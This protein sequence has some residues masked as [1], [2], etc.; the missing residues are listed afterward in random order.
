M[1][2][3]VQT[4][5]AL[6][7]EPTAPSHATNIKWVQEFFQ[8]LKKAPVRL[9]AVADQTGTFNVGDLEFTYT[10]QGPVDID[11]EEVDENDRILFTHQT[12]A[13]ENLLYVCTHKGVAGTDATVL[14]CADDFKSDI[15]PGMTVSVTEGDDHA[16]STWRLTTQG[17]ITAG[18]TALTWEPF[19]PARG[20]EIK[21]VDFTPG[22]GTATA[23]GG[24]EWSLDH[25]LGTDEVQVQL[26]NNATK[27]M[28]MAEVEIED[29]DHVMVRFAVEPTAGSWR[30]IVVG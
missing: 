22:D 17:V 5:L 16:N 24:M 26:Y 19:V 14:T 27:A 25:S 8:G 9:V 6:V 11:D 2:I 20:T 10:A 28:V 29:N 30:A 3:E 7:A 18:T 1:A 4:Q 23:G 13:V 12:N 21:A 15:Q